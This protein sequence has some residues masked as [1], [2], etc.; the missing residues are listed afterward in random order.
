MDTASISAELKASSAAEDHAGGATLP[1]AQGNAEKFHSWF[2]SDV[3][4]GATQKMLISDVVRHIEEFLS[5]TRNN[6][7]RPYLIEGKCVREH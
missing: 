5:L 7:R 6:L 2:F 3:A 4:F 1:S